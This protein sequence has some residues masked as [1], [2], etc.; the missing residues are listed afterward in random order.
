MLF[1]EYSS[2]NVRV[3]RNPFCCKNGIRRI[4]LEYKIP[5]KFLKR[6]KK[7]YKKISYK[8]EHPFEIHFNGRETTKNKFVSFFVSKLLAWSCNGTKILKRFSFLAAE[9]YSSIALFCTFQTY[10]FDKRKMFIHL[11]SDLF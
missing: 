10:N 3:K 1:T 11:A 6:H 2:E 5:V 4:Y 9:L 8:P 7:W